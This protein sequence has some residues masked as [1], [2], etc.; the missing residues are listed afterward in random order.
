ML[1]ALVSAIALILLAEPSRAL[2]R[3][4]ADDQV[5]KARVRSLMRNSFPPARS[6]PCLRGYRNLLHT[7]CNRTLFLKPLR[8]VVRCA[9]AGARLG[10]A[11][12]SIGF[13]LAVDLYTRG[14]AAVRHS[15]H[16]HVLLPCKL[17]QRCRMSCTR[18]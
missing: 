6:M 15:M 1:A 7:Q 4:E 8:D 9:A 10:L 5:A 12:C 16:A 17:K 18:A 14:P 3:S 2:L 13:F 11:L